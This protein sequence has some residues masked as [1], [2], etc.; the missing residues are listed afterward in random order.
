MRKIRLPDAISGAAIAGCLVLG[1]C[2]QVQETLQDAGDGLSNFVANLTP[3]ETETVP[4]DEAMP[5]G[6]MASSSSKATVKA[7]TEGDSGG[8]ALYQAGLSAR[9][10]GAQSKAFEAFRTAG[11]RRHAAA[12]YETARSYMDGL[13]TERDKDKAALWMERSAQLGEARAQFHVG[14]ALQDSQGTKQDEAKGIEW[15]TKAATQG[16]GGAQFALGEA[17]SIGRGVPINATWAARWY[18]KAA[19]QG[20]REAQYAYGLVHARGLGLPVDRT[21]AYRWLLVA[22]RAGHERAEVVRHALEAKMAPEMVKLAE[23]WA[24]R[25]QPSQEQAFTDGPTVMY[26][27]QV[28]NTLG[29]DAGPVDGQAGQQT[30]AAIGAYQKKSGLAR[31]E[32]VSPKLVDRLLAEQ[33]KAN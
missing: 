13:G 19:R 11:E 18:G 30:R 26:V 20:L 4:E 31:D 23:S 15:L 5:P 9:A 25:F 21:E 10:R 33:A 27:Q 17:Y 1:S 12:A 2:A 7:A 22:A 8:E 16:H 14:Q 28:L 3:D 29:Y 6:A 32:Q 24:E